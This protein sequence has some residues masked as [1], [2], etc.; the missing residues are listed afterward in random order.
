MARRC[1]ATV[2]NLKLE[3][4]HSELREHCLVPD[5][6]L[7]ATVTFPFSAHLAISNTWQGLWVSGACGC[8]NPCSRFSPVQE[9]P[10]KSGASGLLVKHGPV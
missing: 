5:S 4:Q 10:G 2:R 8:A 3:V 6:C 7:T 9:P 1:P